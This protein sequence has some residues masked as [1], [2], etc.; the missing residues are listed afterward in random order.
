MPACHVT[1]TAFAHSEAIHLVF[2]V[3]DDDRIWYMLTPVAVLEGNQFAYRIYA[4]CASI[5]AR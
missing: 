5:R 3:F 1:L 2:I 4:F